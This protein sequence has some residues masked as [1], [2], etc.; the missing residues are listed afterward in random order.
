LDVSQAI[1]VG[2]IV[3]EAVTNSIKY[4]F[5]YRVSYPEI[6]ISLRQYKKNSLKLTVADNGIGL[7]PDFNIEEATGLGFKLI[8]GL[9]DDIE[10]ELIV[11]TEQGIIVTVVFN[12]SVPFDEKAK[13]TAPEKTIAV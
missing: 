1:P 11:E 2:L 9:V 10:G 13:I 3:N 8:K 7:P 4:A 5:N 12:A 6:S